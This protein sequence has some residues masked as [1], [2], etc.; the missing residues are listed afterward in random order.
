MSIDQ[1]PGTP[2][3]LVLVPG[4]WLGGWAWDEVV[5]S[6]TDERIPAESV[7]LPGMDPAAPRRASSDLEDQASHLGEVVSRLAD[8]AG[9]VVLVAH[10]GANLPVMRL[11]G[12]R[13]E[14]VDHVVWVDSGPQLDGAVAAP[15]LPEEVAEVPLPPFE[16]LGQQASLEGLSSAQLDRFR[17]RSVPQPGP[18]MRGVLRV[19]DD[20]WQGIPATMICSSL[21]SQDVTA[22]AESGHPMMAPVTAVQHLDLVD[23]PTGHWPFWSRPADLAALLAERSRTVAEVRTVRP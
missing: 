10:S 3:T 6:L 20:R 17:E 12:C 11:L 19:E 4:H 21:T 22:M 9:P 7:T 16:E 1:T 13:P 23:L 8:S 5:D 15:G 18:V 14:L 2:A